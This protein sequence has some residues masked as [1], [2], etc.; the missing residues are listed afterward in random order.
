MIPLIAIDR[1]EILK[2][3]ATALY[4]SDAV[5]GVVNFITRENYDGVIL[6]G[7]YL[8]HQSE[9]DYDEFNIQGLVGKDFGRGSII[10]AA[11]YLER[12]ELTTEERRLSQPLSLIHI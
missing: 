5:A 10:L 2:D 6:S 9:G 11:S 12:S 3:G 8:T 4:G 7:N 1:V